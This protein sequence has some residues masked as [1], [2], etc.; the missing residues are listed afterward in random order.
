MEEQLQDDWLDARLREEASYVDDDGFTARVVQHL[1]VRRR[2]SRSMRA[3]ILLS[4]TFMATLAAYVA[5]GGGQ[6][7]ADA[8]AFMVAM[9]LVTVCAIAAC[10]ALIVMAISAYVAFTKTRELRS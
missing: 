3:A 1:P 8:A 4:I 10:C 5:S 2:Q 7:L 9:P 6:F